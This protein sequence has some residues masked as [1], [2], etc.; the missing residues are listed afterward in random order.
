MQL[1]STLLNARLGEV[2]AGSDAQEQAAAFILGNHLLMETKARLIDS[3]QK[4]VTGCLH[5]AYNQRDKAIKI[6]VNHNETRKEE[7]IPVD[8]IRNYLVEAQNAFFAQNSIETFEESYFFLRKNLALIK[9]FMKKTFKG[10]LE[11]EMMICLLNEVVFLSAHGVIPKAI[12]GIDEAFALL[13]A[14]CPKF[15]VPSPMVSVFSND[16][17]FFENFRKK[18]YKN[19]IQLRLLLASCLTQSELGNHQ[20]AIAQAAE[21]LTTIVDLLRLSRMLANFY[22]TKYVLR[23]KANKNEKKANSYQLKIY[24]FSN[25]WVVL[26]QIVKRVEGLVQSNAGKSSELYN[27][28]FSEILK[29]ESYI[30]PELDYSLLNNPNILQN[31]YLLDATILSLA[32]LSFFNFDDQ[33]VNHKLKSEF[34]EISILEKVAFLVVTLYILSTESRFKEHQASNKTPFSRILPNYNGNDNSLK[35]SEIYL[36]KA[37]EFS[38]L[39]LSESFPFVAQIF[40]MFKKFDLGRSKSIPESND[41][42]VEFVYLNRLKNGFRNDSIVPIILSLP[43]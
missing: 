31:V 9:F 32:Q 15:K 11:K 2:P 10:G 26:N 43:P 1:R 17:E 22:L 6:T 16:A 41:D 40:S 13:R 29:K 5:F 38:Y 18:V 23:W 21:S 25:I 3:I 30:L 4:D 42:P 39:F 8:G 28:F 36:T 19:K 12:V 24:Y 33:F 7:M 14:Q 35:P 34:T 27:N 37:T 20:K